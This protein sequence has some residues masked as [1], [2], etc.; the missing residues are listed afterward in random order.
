MRIYSE[1]DLVQL[2]RKLAQA[3]LITQ[4]KQPSAIVIFLEGNLGAGKT[5]LSRAIIENLGFTGAIKSPTY[6]LVESYSFSQIKVFH[7][8]LYRLA[9]PE[10]LEFIGIRDYLSANNLLLIEWAERGEEFLPSAD[11]KIKLDFV[12]N[13]RKLEFIAITPL[14]KNL[15]Q[16][17]N[18]E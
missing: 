12:D 9:D 11:L 7:F 4:L 5:F 13:G 1:S 10:E 15:L 6:T 2:G 8:D 14:G 17:A 3:V 16:Q 18:L